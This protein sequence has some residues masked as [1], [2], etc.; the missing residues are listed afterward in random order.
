MM[1]MQRVLPGL[2]FLLGGIF[3]GTAAGAQYSAYFTNQRFSVPTSATAGTF[4]GGTWTTTTV[5]GM[6]NSISTNAAPGALPAGSDFPSSGPNSVLLNSGT[7]FKT[8][9]ITFSAPFTPAD[10][11]YLQ[12]MDNSEV[13]N[14]SFYDA[15]NVLIDPSAFRASRISTNFNA[16]F[17]MSQ[18]ST[19]INISGGSGLATEPLLEIVPSV[20]VASIQ[21]NFN[22][23]NAGG[24]LYYFGRNIPVLTQ[25]LSGST[26]TR[27]RSLRL[28]YTL[29]GIN[30]N[31]IHELGFSNTLPSGWKVA[32]TPAESGSIGTLSAAPNAASA[33][34]SDIN[35]SFLSS[36]VRT[37]AVWSFDVTNADGQMNSSCSGNPPA[38]SNTASN[39]TTSSTVMTNN[40][41]PVCFTVTAPLPLEL[42]SFSA[43]A[44]AC[45]TILR[46]ESGYE[47]SLQGYEIERSEDGR[48]WSRIGSLPARNAR[49]AQHYSFEDAA[50]PSGNLAYRLRI[51]D[52]SGTGT[53]SP[54]ASV[55]MSCGGQPVQ[56]SFAPNPASSEVSC[57]LGTAPAA[58]ASVRL[59]ITD[60]AGRRVASLSAGSMSGTVAQFGL[61][62]LAPGLYLVQA[63]IDGRPVGSGK[64]IIR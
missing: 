15:S 25:T 3:F 24:F 50:P 55:K 49:Q 59:Q 41:S 61:P 16:G 5:A 51:R 48:H 28:T 9:R 38:F 8:I 37:S 33:S 20:P 32:A 27:G 46:W 13:V 54:V 1:R 11:F 29:G 60:L 63:S 23:P 10:H 30:N 4:A 39:F 2:A 53:F 47:E 62:S 34:L 18:S 64:L 19:A 42:K 58:T 52:L 57:D 17:S 40:V 21:L 43:N 12:D 7:G 31:P 14:V 56:L 6:T 22:N 45:A 26:I 44:S 36:N 35:Y